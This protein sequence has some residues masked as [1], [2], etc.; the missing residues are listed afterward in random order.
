[1]ECKI[2]H[3]AAFKVIGYSTTISRNEGYS[4]CP[5]FWDKEYSQKY[6]RL[7]KSMQPQTEEERAILDNKIGAYALCIDGTDEFEYMIA[8]AYQGGNVPKSMKL[9]EFPESDWAIFT[10]KGAMPKALQ[11]LNDYVWNEWYPTDGQKYLPNATATVEYYSVGD[12]QS[13][14]YVSGIWVPIKKK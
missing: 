14:D 2:E 8:G 4:K 12:M 1:M 10:T 6:E 5:E 11:D 7:F 9:F 3:K 13:D